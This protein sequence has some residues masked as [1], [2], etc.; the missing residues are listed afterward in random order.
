MILDADGNELVYW[1]ISGL[2]EGEDS[3]VLEFTIPVPDYPTML[4][5]SLDD[6]GIVWA[7]KVGDA[8][9]VNISTTPYDLSA[10]SGFQDF[11]CYVEALTPIVGL[12]RVPFSVVAGTGSPA[13]WVT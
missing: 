11:Q 8:G 7:R 3:E 10:L 1:P 2:I 6:R 12:E 13:G 5:A 9:Y 4:T